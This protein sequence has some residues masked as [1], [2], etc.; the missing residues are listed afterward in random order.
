[1]ITTQQPHGSATVIVMSGTRRP[2][3]SMQDPMKLGLTVERPVSDRLTALAAAAGVS[4]AVMLEWLVTNVRLNDNGV[5]ADW[6]HP[7][8]EGQLPM[9]RTG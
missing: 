9:Q 1:M 3:G 6:P 8:E 5:P 7:P 4:K 2:H